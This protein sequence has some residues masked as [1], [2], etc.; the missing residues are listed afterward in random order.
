MATLFISDLHLDDSQPAATGWLL[1]FLSGPARTADAVYILGDL[2][3][4]WIGDD[5]L[6]ATARQVA[7]ATSAL[8]AAGVPCYFMHGNRDFLLGDAYAAQAGLEL[9]PD[10]ALVDLYGTPT[11]L[12]HGDTLCTEDTEYQLFRQ[13]TRDPRW[14]ARILTLSVEERLQLARSARDASI[15]H[16]GSVSMD[17]M[18]VNETAVRNAF[19]DH[20]VKRMIQKELCFPTGIPPAVIF[21]S[22]QTKWNLLGFQTNFLPV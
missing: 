16:T 7:Q 4:Y 11:L 9:L 3:E 17:I 5:A 15:A 21:G 20:A 18:D 10:V 14:L 22:M 1:D 13:Q 12:L 2:F 19:R 8:K 6:S